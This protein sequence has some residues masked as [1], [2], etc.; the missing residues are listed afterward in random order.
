MI[1]IIASINYA[2]R[3]PDLATATAVPLLVSFDFITKFSTQIINSVSIKDDDDAIKKA[4][5]NE[6][7][8][9][10]NWWLRV[11]IPVVIMIGVVVAALV[12]ACLSIGIDSYVPVN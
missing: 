5:D 9:D 1:I 7:W 6:T 2:S 3:A 11:G 4:N 8:L 12:L 10:E